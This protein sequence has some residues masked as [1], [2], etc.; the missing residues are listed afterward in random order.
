LPA[1]LR[2]TRATDT[3]IVQSREPPPGEP[4]AFFG[5]LLGRMKACV[6]RSGL[7]PVL[8]GSAVH[9]C[10]AG[11]LRDSGVVLSAEGADFLERRRLHRRPSLVR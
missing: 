2:W 7:R 6:A 11:R 1:D 4:S 10:L 9:A 8:D 5:D 3:G